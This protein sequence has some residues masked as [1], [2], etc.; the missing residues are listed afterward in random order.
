MLGVGPGMKSKFLAKT[1]QQNQQ[2]S[3]PAAASQPP[4]INFYPSSH[5]QQEHMINSGNFMHPQSAK[6]IYAAAP[7]NVLQE[8]HNNYNNV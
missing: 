7:G 1:S 5:Q 6:P 4:P 8:S 2:P 3:Q